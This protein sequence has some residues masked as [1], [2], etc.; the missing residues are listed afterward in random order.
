MGAMQAP[1]DSLIPCDIEGQ[2]QFSQGSSEVWGFG[3]SQAKLS[4]VRQLIP[5]L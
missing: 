3:E 5:K 1:F 2:E 4:N